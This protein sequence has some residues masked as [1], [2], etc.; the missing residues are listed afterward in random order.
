MAKLKKVRLQLRNENTDEVLQDVD[1]LTSEDC[2]TFEDRETYN[3]KLKNLGL[4]GDKGD[5]GWNEAVVPNIKANNIKVLEPEKDVEVIRG[6]SKENPTIS[7][8]IPKGE[9]ED[10]NIPE[11]VKARRIST[12]ETFDSLDERINT[13]IN[14]INQ[15]IDTTWLEQKDVLDQTVDNTIDGTTI[16]MSIKGRTL[17][18]LFDLEKTKAA[19]SDEIT[20]H[21]DGRIECLLDSA[22]LTFTPSCS[23]KPTTAYTLKITKVTSDYNWPISI[24]Y[25]DGSS[26]TVDIRN[27]IKVSNPEKTIDRIV[28]RHASGQ[29]LI[30]RDIMILEGDW[31]GKEI[32]PHFEGIKSAG[33]EDGNK[34]EILSCGK[35]LLDYRYNEIR[36]L[37]REKIEQI[38]RGFRI[39]A[40]VEQYGC[41]LKTLK[42]NKGTYTLSC[43]EKPIEN[44]FQQH[45]GIR[46]K[47]GSKWLA[48]SR[49]RLQFS[50]SNDNEDII[51]SYYVGT[52]VSD[53]R[54]V[55]EVTDIQLEKNSIQTPYEPYVENKETINLSIENG[56]KGI[57]EVKDEI[58]MKPDGVYLVQKI[59]KTVLSGSEYWDYYAPHDTEKTLSFFTKISDSLTG[60]GEINAISNTFC[61]V[62]YSKYYQSSTGGVFAGNNQSGGMVFFKVDKTKISPQD[63]SG[64]KKLIKENPTTVYYQL[65][66]PKEHKLL[67]IS[68]INLNTYKG[69]TYITSNNTIKPLLSFKTLGDTTAIIE[70]LSRDNSKIKKQIKYQ[71]LKNIQQEK[72]I[73]ETLLS[74]ANIH[75]LALVLRGDV[76]TLEESGNKDIFEE[77]YKII[78]E[79][80]LSDI[81]H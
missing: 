10:P 39:T 7:F 17:Q 18:N 46:A 20:W 74:I 57:G 8:R 50:V 1:I 75:Q 30:I 34:I 36:V 61:G 69:I 14:R 5:D 45:S 70:D 31:T 55:I 4:K 29:T 47:V 64:F 73:D 67:D 68:D 43:K 76:E 51:V 16:D 19:S 52:P 42:L 33:E 80:G 66:E 25:T 78:D 22:R 21:S 3:E 32:P 15:D 56:L 38:E 35:N 71:I 6:G 44:D 81:S 41:Q 49:D 26:D 53:K 59:N 24:I 37:S 65:A 60:N 79:R 54:K 40:E 9:V 2:V 23:Y 58:I 27:Q 72:R 11:I 48:A 13:E 28:K 63:I 77:I 62:E 12:G